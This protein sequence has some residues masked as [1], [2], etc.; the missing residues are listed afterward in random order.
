MQKFTK[1]TELVRFDWFM[2]NMF[3]DKRD[4][5]ILEGFLSVLLK[6]DITIIEILESESNQENKKDKFNRVDMMVKTAKDERIIVEIQNNEE[7]DYLQRILYGAC[8][9]ITENL[10][11]GE[12][13]ALVKK[14][15]SV[16]IV[17][18]E[19]GQGRDYVYHGYTNFKGLHLNDELL[20]NQE[21]QKA[22]KK[23]TPAQLMPEYYLIQALS[24]KDMIN[25]GLDEWVYLFK[26]SQVEDNFTA[27]GINKAKEK[28]AVAKLTKK[29]R[30]EYDRYLKSLHSE[31][32]WNETQ[33]IKAEREERL[34]KETEERVRDEAK[35]EIAAAIAAEKKVAKDALA[36][37]LAVEK[38]VA[39]DA[40]AEALAAEKKAAK[41]TLTAEKK[42]AK[43]ALVAEKKVAKEALVA[44]KKAAKLAAKLAAE[45]AELK[46]K[47]N[48]II[49]GIEIGLDEAT[50]SKMLNVP[51]TYVQQIKAELT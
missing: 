32:S 23:Q 16:S 2:K 47:K 7:Y 18:F 36:E 43:E 48:T 44:E 17:Y 13:Y 28:L 46:M 38:K 42:A 6:E 19:T 8:K 14:V 5:D 24:F 15:I 3:R 26:Y 51:I 27:K 21:Q 29:K 11:K 39:K 50:I 20:L 12:A 33:R 41:E 30:Q 22:F 37:A 34:V 25:D 49:N 35:A 9:T 31:A 10:K 40:L 1:F 4:F 45:E